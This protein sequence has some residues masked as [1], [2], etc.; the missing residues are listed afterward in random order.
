MI[1]TL[2]QAYDNGW[3]IHIACAWGK[4]DGLK[5]IRECED[6]LEIDMPTLLWTRGRG[7]PLTL[8]QDRMRCPRCGSRRVRVHFQPP[9]NREASRASRA[10]AG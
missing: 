4:K 9:A 6:R 1:E 3:R 8:L 7:F 5:S 2:G 10:S